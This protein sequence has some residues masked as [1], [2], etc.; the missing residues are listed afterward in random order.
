MP[1]FERATEWLGGEMFIT[2][3]GQPTLVQFWAISCPI[4]KMNVPRLLEFLDTYQSSGLRLVSVHMPRMEADMDTAEV[5][6]A[7]AEMNLVGPCA[8]DNAH[9]VGD[10]FRTGGVWPCYFFF[11][12][13]GR[14]RSRAAGALGL[15][16]AEK[17]L[18]RLLSQNTDLQQAASAPQKAVSA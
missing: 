16:M 11:D 4:C 9:V 3:T 15:K 6:Q 7:M 12:A 1:S 8:I 18:A 2:S 5:R 10:R 17:S 13:G 14:L